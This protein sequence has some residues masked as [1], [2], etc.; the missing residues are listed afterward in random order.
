MVEIGYASWLVI[1]IFI[2]IVTMGVLL[3]DLYVQKRVI[4]HLNAELENAKKVIDI[5][6][7]LLNK[8][9]NTYPKTGQ[10]V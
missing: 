1:V 10:M 4:R 8:N 6:V 2:S 3:A 7:R 9:T 5:Q